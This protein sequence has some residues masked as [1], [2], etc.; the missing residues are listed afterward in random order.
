M[1]NWNLGAVGKQSFTKYILG[2]E[3]G[4]SNN[5]RKEDS[6]TRRSRK[7]GFPF[8]NP[9]LPVK[10]GQE[11]FAKL[12]L[13]SHPRWLPVLWFQ[14]TDWFLFPSGELMMFQKKKK[15][16]VWSCYLPTLVKK[17]TK[18]KEN[19]T[20]VFRKTELGGLRWSFCKPCC[21]VAPTRGKEK[22]FPLPE[23]YVG[24]LQWG[25]LTGKA[26]EGVVWLPK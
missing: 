8:Q 10:V 5:L 16:M 17:K 4:W 19:E 22:N 6:C 7:Q 20:K 18:P 23:R 11:Q 13:V 26:L 21:H 9:N 12:L 24:I 3:Q 14:A 25:S 1:W 15:W 2:I